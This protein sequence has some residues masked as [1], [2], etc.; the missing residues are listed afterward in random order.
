LER[1]KPQQSEHP[2]DLGATSRQLR[3]QFDSARAVFAGRNSD[4]VI[5]G[6]EG[7]SVRAAELC[8]ALAHQVIN[9][10]AQ[11]LPGWMGRGY[12]WPTRLFSKIGVSVSGI[13][14]RPTSLFEDLLRDVPEMD[15]NL[16]GTIVENYCVGGYVPPPKMQAFVDLL[17]K[18]RR[19]LILAWH[20]DHDVKDGAD[21]DKLAPDFIKILEPAT[22]ALRHGHGFIEVAE[23]YSGILGW[24][25]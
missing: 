15:R 21:L 1:I 2:P 9:L 8:P 3:K 13:F 7:E 10:A 16:H 24:M 12:V 20:E 18:H 17:M 5:D 25:N 23:V 4:A 19:E 22:H 6:D 11:V 14:E